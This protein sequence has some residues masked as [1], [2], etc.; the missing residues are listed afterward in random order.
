MC[1][2][3]IYGPTDITWVYCDK[4]RHSTRL[5]WIIQ[6]TARKRID[7]PYT[8]PIS[9]WSYMCDPKFPKGGCPSCPLDLRQYHN[10]DRY[11]VNFTE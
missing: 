11:V 7:C 5:D 4:V 8:D 9:F 1:G 10:F 6:R 2:A 3:I